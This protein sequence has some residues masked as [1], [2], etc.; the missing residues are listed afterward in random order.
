MDSK[1]A[2]SCLLF[3]FLVSLHSVISQTSGTVNV[4][5]SLTAMGQNPPWLSPSNDFAFGFRQISENN[6]FFLLAIW[7]YKIPDR[8]VVWYANGGNP[9]PRGS[10]VELTAD[11]G[12]VLKDPRDSEI[13]RSGF[14]VG[15]VTHGA[16]NDTGNFV[17]FNVNSGSQALWQS[18]S[19]PTDTLL[20]TQIMKIEGMLSSRKSETNFSQGRFQF[21]LLRT[22]SAVLNPINLP[23]KY[24]YD[25]YYTTGTRD[26]ANSSN[27]G[28]QVV[29]D[30]L[31][32]LYVRKRNDERFNLTP[33]EMVPVTGYYHKATLNFDGVFT[34]SHHPKSSSSNETWTVITTIPS[35]I[36]LGLNGPRGSG[37][38]GFN[39]VCKLKDDQRPTCECP[40]GYSLVDPDDKYGS[41]KPDFLQGCEVDGQRPQEDLYTTVELRNTDWPPSDYDL[42][43]PCSQE[44]CRKSCMQDCFC[45]AA[46]SKYDNCWKKKLPLSNGRKDI[47]VSSVAFLKVRRANSTLQNPLCPPPN[48]EKNQD[49][50]IVIVSVLLGGSVVVVFVLAGLLCS[51]PFFYHK[52]HTEKHQQE[53]SMGMNLRCLTYKELEDAT[54]GFD[55]ELGRG[56]FGIVYKGV[57]ETGSTVP[58]SI[59]VKKLDRL[60][61]DGDEEFK[62]EVKVI[63]QTHHK[64]LVRLLGYCNE[65]QNRLL[66]YEFLSNGTLASLLFGD[67]KPSWYQR[68]QIALGTGKGL[69]YLHEEC[70]TQIIH[71]DIKPQN[72]LLDDS[73]NAR[74]SDFGLAK[75]LMINQTHTKT[76]IRGTKGYVAPEW[77]R[78]KPITVKVDVY[79]FGVMLLEIISCRRSVGIETGENDREIL[80]DWAYDC[81]RRGTLDALVDDD[82]EA[83]SDM[84]RLEKYVMI[85]LWCIQEDPSLRPTMKKVM[86]ML[87]GIVQVAIPPCPCSFSGTIS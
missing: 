20:P 42:I 79:S 55:E 29:F 76:N 3:S 25:Q 31:G 66:V 22:G 51:G 87:E 15:T 35:N 83:T 46:V 10:K 2:F 62:T 12:L 43:K 71:C 27:A 82:P 85:A 69:L 11:R 8:T 45:A 56:S 75:L 6:D 65:G 5:E 73:Y 33:H 32:Y 72:I 44:D 34:I 80:T 81:F 74:I 24:P 23:T 39:N 18:F 78:S 64:N 36:C 9:A 67:L 53:S 26:A 54:N 63:G 41:C 47:A 84:K 70:S 37:I 61:K 58:I 14:S 30:E 38:C 7:Y 17:L 68:T 40:P 77:F 50:L 48:A 19:Y 21:R 28:I 4:G 13:W 60:V 49:S 16:M 59:A 52:K 86:L 1:F 57:I